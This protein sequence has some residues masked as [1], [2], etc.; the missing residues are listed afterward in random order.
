M[1]KLR[2]AQA[3]KDLPAT[4]ARSRECSVFHATGNDGR[5]QLGL[6][7]GAAS[8]GRYLPGAP[9]GA[10]APGLWAWQIR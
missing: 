1:R 9:Q 3:G 4:G 8:Q 2:Q 7:Y 10:E 6:R 5:Y